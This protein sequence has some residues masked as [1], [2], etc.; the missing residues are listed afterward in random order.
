MN[1]FIETLLSKYDPKEKELFLKAKFILI[2]TVVV[3]C[4]L[5]ITLI[6]TSYLGGLNTNVIFAEVVGFSIMLLALGMLIKGKYELA[7]HIILITGF[8]TT[9]MVL[10]LEDISILSK[11]D[12]IVFIIGLL[13]VMPLM[14]FR[15]RKPMV[16]YFILNMIV[17]IIFNYYLYLTAGLTKI[18]RLDYFFDNTIVMI[19]VFFVAY[20]L[21]AIYQQTLSTL[22]VELADRKKAEEALKKSENLFRLITGHTSALVSIHDA[23]GCYI[24]VSTSYEQLGYKPEEL[25]GKSGLTMMEEEDKKTFLELLEKAKTG[26]MPGTFLSS[27]L[28]DKKGGIHYCSGSFDTVLKSDGSLEGVICVLEDITQLR[29]AQTEKIK[30]LTLA[31][32]A[33]KM[34]LVGQIAGK[35]AHDFNNILGVVMGNTELALIDCPDDETGKRLKLILDQT[36]HGKN[37]TKNLVAFAKDQEPKQEFFDVAEKMELI[38]A[39]LKKDLEDIRVI[40]EYSSTMPELLADPGMIEHAIV[41]LVQN[42]IHATSLV[43]NPEI[44]IRTYHRN[45]CIFIEIE[46]NGCGIPEEFLKEIFEP[47]FTLKGNKDKDA[48][49]K[50]DI[51]GTGYGMSNVKRYVEQH[52]GYLAV[53]SEIQ[54]G[55]ILTISLPVIKKELTNNEKED[56]EKGIV[57]FEKYIL[58][59]EDEQSI[60]E[61]QH[62]IL[63]HEPCN[64]KV[65]IAGSGKAATDLFDKNKYDLISLDYILPGELN[66]MDVYQYIRK[67]DTSVPILFVSGNIEFLESIKALK[68]KDPYIDHVSKP[69]R[70]IDYL[71]SINKLFEI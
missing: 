69:C 5:L 11:L 43:K 4:A 24:F 42:S 32:D 47:S 10:F 53:Q 44:T 22:K 17:F 71:D 45:E 49:Y 57:C 18:E 39:L 33:E 35:M 12:T 20:A 19:F 34:A 2:T 55:T 27:R 48:M 63:T 9:W 54:K 29:K 36:I 59:I 16:I 1:K 30:A 37:L 66:G 56:I 41:N 70:N 14:F 31:A 52:K 6:Y 21:F 38:I 50:P 25:I 61:V 13:A 3:I 7:I 15:N 64:H 58:L 23:A 68:Q 51:K 46:D 62:N 8:F 26:K 67:T 40:R 28:K 65:D 60:S